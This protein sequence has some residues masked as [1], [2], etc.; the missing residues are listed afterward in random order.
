MRGWISP[1]LGVQF[2]LEGVDLCLTRP[3]GQ[4]FVT[5]LGVAQRAENAEQR[6]AA[7]ESELAR[8][9][10]LLKQQGIDFSG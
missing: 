6:A 4:R 7:A 5:Y 10:A 2:E 1:R 8:L 9:R 3:N